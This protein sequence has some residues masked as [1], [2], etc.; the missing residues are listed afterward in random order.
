MYPKPRFPVHF[1]R[2]FVRHC[3]PSAAVSAKS[4]AVDFPVACAY[5]TS[6][7]LLS[8]LLF[9]CILK[10]GRLTLF[11]SVYRCFCYNLQE[12][13]DSLPPVPA[14]L[15]LLSFPLCCLVCS[16]LLLPLLSIICTATLFG[17]FACQLL[18]F[19]EV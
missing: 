5:V 19:E 3:L 9:V 16:V 15:L 14:F 11:L 10:E 13:W 18:Q 6:V 17:V 4:S 7:C 2:G 8:F 1:S 12:R